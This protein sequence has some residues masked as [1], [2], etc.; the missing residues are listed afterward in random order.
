MSLAPIIIVSSSITFLYTP[1]IEF[2]FVDQTLS[3]NEQ[4]EKMLLV[5]LLFL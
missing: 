2:R 3:K 4:T 5:L 1:H